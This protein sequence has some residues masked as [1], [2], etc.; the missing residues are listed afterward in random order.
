MALGIR[1]RWL[2][3]SLRSFLLLVTIVACCIGPYLMELRNRRIAVNRVRSLGGS[4]LYE[5]QMDSSTGSYIQGPERY[6][7]TPSGPTWLKSL[8]GAEVFNTPVNVDLSSTAIKDA[9]LSILRHMPELRFV[10]LEQTRITDAGLRHLIQLENLRIV[11][12][13]FA[14]VTEK[15]VEELRLRLPNVE[16]Q[17]EIEPIAENGWGIRNWR[18]QPET[19]RLGIQS[20]RGDVRVIHPGSPADLAGMTIGDKILSIN[21][22]KIASEVPI[23]GRNPSDGSEAMKR[24]LAD[25]IPREEKMLLKIVKGMPLGS[26]I[27]LTV[28]RNEEEVALLAALDG[29]AH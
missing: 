1:R 13:Q 11:Y 12:L 22:T 7:I 19:T 14:E 21:G 18:V 26:C 8:V 27:R 10:G 17:Y 28:A 24:S 15:G 3:F 16:I 4:I 20:F 9:D 5:F 2:K 29:A 23:R 6:E 25:M